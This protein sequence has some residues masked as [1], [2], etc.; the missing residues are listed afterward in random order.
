M[1]IK[2]IYIGFIIYRYVCVYSV[3][4]SCL[5]VTLWTIACHPPL[6][7]GFSRQEYWNG[8]PF[9]PPGNLPNPGIE[10]TSPT[11]ADRFFTTEPP[12]KPRIAQKRG[13]YRFIG[14]KF[15]HHTGIC[16]LV[17][18]LCPTLSN[19]MDCSPPGSSFHRISQAR[20]LDWVAIFYSRGSF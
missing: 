8:L 4:K 16:C 15:L 11:L 13:R 7:M 19:P 9:P 2:T 6:S 10:S 1:I 3:I 18:Q 12:G 14:I 17:G 5:T 20:I